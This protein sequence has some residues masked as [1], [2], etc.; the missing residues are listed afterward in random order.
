MFLSTGL[1]WENVG[2]GDHQIQDETL[3]LP[4]TEQYNIRQV[5]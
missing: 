2:F 4:L 1:E 5:T 3:T